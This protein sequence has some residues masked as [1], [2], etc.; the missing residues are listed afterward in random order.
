[1]KKPFELFVGIIAASV[2]ALTVT[3]YLTSDRETK[4]TASE[5]VPHGQNEKPIANSNR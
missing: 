5:Y 2:V 1:M 4:K 3:L